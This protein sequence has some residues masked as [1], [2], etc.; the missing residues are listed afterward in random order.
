MDNNY[1]KL[2]DT[3][4]A[5]EGNVFITINGQNRP[6]FEVVKINANIAKDIKEKK[7]LGN[8][9]TQHKIIGASISGSATLAL[10]NGDLLKATVDYLKTG[11]YPPI[12]IQL[13]NLDQ[14][15]TVGTRQAALTGV[16]FN[17][18]LISMLDSDSDDIVTY[19]TDFTADGIE[20]LSDFG[21][22]ANYK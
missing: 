13:K 20:L 8:R 21:L 2:S 15:S 22:P 12:T 4:S 7:M 16:I 6:L 3:L 19:D 17:T 18:D 9:I 1:V 11:V 14:A 10:M 5:Q